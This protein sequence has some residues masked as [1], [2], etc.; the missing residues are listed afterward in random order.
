V[1]FVPSMTDMRDEATARGHLRIPR[2][3]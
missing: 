3:S 1:S 2:F